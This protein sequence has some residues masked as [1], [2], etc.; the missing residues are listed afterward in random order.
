MGFAVHLRRKRIVSCHWTVDSRP[1]ASAQGSWGRMSSSSSGGCSRALNWPSYRRLRFRAWWSCWCFRTASC[2][3]SIRRPSARFAWASSWY[4]GETTVPM[5]AFAVHFQSS[6]WRSSL[7]HCFR[8]TPLLFL[9]PAV[10]FHALIPSLVTLGRPAAA[11][12]SSPVFLM[13]LR[14]VLHS[15][16]QLSSRSVFF[17]MIQLSAT[18]LT[19]LCEPA[20]R[21]A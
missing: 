8:W 14:W 21:E 3:I 10:R 11:I 19:A 15:F 12:N 17:T 18:N 6:W 20:P 4:V 16:N 2:T 5:R 13:H 7:F 1:L 9:S